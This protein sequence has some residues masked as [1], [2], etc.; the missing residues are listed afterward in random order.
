MLL[1]V[2]RTL[3]S[4]L[5]DQLEDLRLVNVQLCALAEE[6]RALA[7]AMDFGLLY[8]RRRRLLHIGLHVDSG[9]LDRGHYDLLASEARLTSLVAIAKGDVPAGHW[10]ALGRPF[11]A[12]GRNVVLRSWSGSMFEYLMPALV[13]EEPLGSALQRSGQGAVAEHMR[14]G[15]AHATP[16]GMSESAIALQDHT[17]AYQYGPQGVARLAMRRTPAHERVIAPYASGLAL[18]VHPVAA[19]ANLRALERLD[20]RRALGFIEAIDYSPQRQ[21]SGQTHTLVQTHMAHHQAMIFI[22]AASVLTEGLPQAWARRQP[23]LRAVAALLHERAPR[24]ALE[25]RELRSPPPPPRTRRPPMVQVSAPLDD[26]MPP[27][28]WLGNRRY[29][30]VL[31]SNGAGYSHCHGQGLTRWRDDLLRDDQ[32]S[33]IYLQRAGGAP[34]SV[35]AHPAPDRDATYACRIQPDRV[36]F[37]CHWTDLDVSTAVWVSPEDDCELRQV[38]SSTAA[39]TNWTWC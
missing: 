17:M 19:V 12:Q 22:A 18:L 8:D 24:E 33:F 2:V 10:Q 32:G 1:D 23:H 11:G 25:L 34:H 13:L 39:N 28:Q 31:R 6:A 14:E 35:T 7:L 26:A 5:R 27:T 21:A 36:V 38:D 4:H 20:A 3:D 9:Q 16:W 29:G 37:E 30:V 15:L